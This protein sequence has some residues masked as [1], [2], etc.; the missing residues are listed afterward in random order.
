MTKHEKIKYLLIPAIGFG[1]G[2]ALWGWRWSQLFEEAGINNFVFISG[3]ILFGL[4]GGLF[5]VV[6]ENI[7]I[8]RKIFIV[9]VGLIIWIVVLYMWVVS[10]DFS[11]F[12]FPTGIILFPSLL[13][14]IV[15]LLYSLVLN[16]ILRTKIWPVFWLADD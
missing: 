13:G 12:V 15:G 11:V 4:F 8:L 10:Y 5:L 14:I 1:I 2:G 16:S 3:A 7:K 9:L 6:L